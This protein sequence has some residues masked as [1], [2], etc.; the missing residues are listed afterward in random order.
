MTLKAPTHKTGMT[1]P[2]NVEALPTRKVADYVADLARAYGVHYKRTAVEAWAEAVTRAAGD[3]VSVD[4]TGGLLV[5][6]KQRNV[7]NAAQ[8]TRLL[9][10]H[11]RERA[12]V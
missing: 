9:V 11:R 3:E 8:F 7:L 4:K 12:I 10:N 2:K 1:I 5:R 6:L